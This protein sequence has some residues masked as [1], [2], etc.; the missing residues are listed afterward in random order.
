MTET[1][2]SVVR[3]MKK[4]ANGTTVA[5]AETRT[6][7][8]ANNN[9]KGLTPEQMVEARRQAALKARDEDKGIG[10]NNV[11][12]YPKDTLSYTDEQ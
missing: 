3:I 8:N 12:S 6:S 11:A 7:I 9:E 2:N 10:K 5:P 4:L 1:N